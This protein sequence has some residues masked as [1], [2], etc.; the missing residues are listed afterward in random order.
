MV[1]KAR[2]SARWILA[3]LCSPPGWP[4]ASLSFGGHF[5]L[6]RC[7]VDATTVLSVSLDYLNFP[8]LHS[9]DHFSGLF[10]GGRLSSSNLKPF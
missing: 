1:L 4:G 10:L 6:P 3:D 2:S 9:K 5:N 8:V 7:E